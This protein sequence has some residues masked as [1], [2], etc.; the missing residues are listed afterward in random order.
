M[1]SSTKL[2][3][4]SEPSSQSKW[5]IIENIIASCNNEVVVVA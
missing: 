4:I 1:P 5:G 2:F 3:G